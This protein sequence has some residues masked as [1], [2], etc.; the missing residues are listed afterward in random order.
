MNLQ[1]NEYGFRA[2][3]E[4]PYK[5]QVLNHTDYNL[6]CLTSTCYD[7]DMRYIFDVVYY[8][9]TDNTIVTYY[10]YDLKIFLDA[11]I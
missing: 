2:Y 10:C 11:I 1:N 8:N 5:G 3:T 4:A 9:D 6:F 7:F